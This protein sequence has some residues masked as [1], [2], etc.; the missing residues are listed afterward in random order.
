MEPAYDKSRDK[1]LRRLRQRELGSFSSPSTFPLQLGANPSLVSRLTLSATLNAHSGCV[2]TISWNETGEFL[3][4]GRCAFQ[5]TLKFEMNSLS[6]KVFN[7]RLG[8]NF[9][10]ATFFIILAF[11]RPVF[12]LVLV[13]RSKK[14]SHLNF[15]LAL[16]AVISFLAAMTLL[17]ASGITTIIIH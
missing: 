9:I 16:T 11:L 1:W 5:G 2:N 15:L 10:V 14:H 6:S 8:S 7:A 13:K 17:S 12:Q 4:S 3:V